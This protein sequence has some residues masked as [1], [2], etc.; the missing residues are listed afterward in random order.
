LEDDMLQA[1]VSLVT[2]RYGVRAANSMSNK[3]L[4]KVMAVALALIAPVIAFKPTPKPSTEDGDAAAAPTPAKIPA[5]LDALPVSQRIKDD[6]MEG[7]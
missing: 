6:A 5:W 3:G 1:G 2:V 4:T 7:T